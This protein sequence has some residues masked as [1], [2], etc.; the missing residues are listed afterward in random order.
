M[1]L[2]AI[3]TK[4]A[5]VHF[6]KTNKIARALRDLKCPT[7]SS[8]TGSCNLGSLKNLQVLPYSKLHKK[9]HVITY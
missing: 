3:W 7:Y 1:I 2:N 4:E 6:S 8:L 5:R 9:N